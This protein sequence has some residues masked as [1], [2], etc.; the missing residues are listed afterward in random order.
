LDSKFEN[1]QC[2]GIKIRITEKEKFNAIDFGIKLI[3]ALYQLYPKEFQFRTDHFDK[4]IGS[5]YIREK[6]I[7]GI[8]PD[9]IIN[10]WQKKLDQFK[11]KRK[12]YLLY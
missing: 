2:N 12:S 3:C 9:S 5:D 10:S 6:I 1:E 8:H 7:D 11:E 4:L